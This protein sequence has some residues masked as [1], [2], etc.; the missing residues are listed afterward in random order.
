MQ[1][2]PQSEGGIG[3]PPPLVYLVAMVLGVALDLAVPLPLLPMVAALALGAVLVTLAVAL[4][5]WAFR[6][7]AAAGESPN[8]GQPTE[9]IVVG[10]P[11]RRSRNP[12]YLAM[13]LLAAGVALLVNSGWGLALL[14]PAL[15]A[16]HYGAIRHEERYLERT[17]G[18]EYRAYRARV[19]RWI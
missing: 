7:M 4:G 12:L 14:V 19:R 15:I 6:T 13:T 2:E 17:F 11:F 5:G 18:D 1:P 8:P 9:A 3:L 16:I 10:G